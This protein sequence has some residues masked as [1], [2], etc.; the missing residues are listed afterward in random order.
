MSETLDQT[1][2]AVFPPGRYGRRDGPAGVRLRVLSGRALVQ[3]MAR[4]GNDHSI[5][6]AVRSKYQ[7]ALPQ[8]PLLA[9]G[10][11][12]LFLWNGHLT[13][14]AVADE[15]LIPDLESALCNDLGPLA[16]LSDQSDSRFTVEL[17]GSRARDALAKLA[18]V[19]LH[20]RAFRPGDTAMTLLGHL[21]GQITQIDVT[22]SY[23]LMVFRGFAE[24][25]L[26]DLLEAGAEFGV[27]AIG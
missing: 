26:H 20:P 7:L 10:P 12:L 9:R 6:D 16:S 25:F 18:P 8:T 15:G 5:R 2:A 13:W 3:V 17:S 27:E 14:L 11:Q 22:P 19:D 4:G 1:P 24:S 23:E 21:T